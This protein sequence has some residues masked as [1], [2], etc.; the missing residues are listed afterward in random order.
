MK[1]TAV[2]GAKAIWLFDLNLL[3]PKGLSYKPLLDGFKDRYKFS[4]APN[5]MLDRDENNK[6]GLTFDQGEFHTKDGR[7]IYVSL[8]VFNDG[9]VGS[10][11]SSTNDTTEFLEDIRLFVQLE[12]FSI[13]PDEKIGKSFTSTLQVESEA[14][15]LAINPQLERLIQFIESRVVTM[16]GRPREFQVTGLALWSEDASKNYAPS[17]FKFERKLGLPFFA[18]QFFTEAPLQTHE[19]LELLEDLERLLRT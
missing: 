4:V 8:K 6:G 19:H 18:N 11:S 5:H 2:L 14:P 12:G 10:T 9:L 13:P 1:L 15:L 17:T 7:D 3:N 16:D